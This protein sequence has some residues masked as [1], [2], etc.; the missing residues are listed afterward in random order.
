MR[1]DERQNRR[2]QQRVVT[3]ASR[4]VARHVEPRVPGILHVEDARACAEG[5]FL[6]GVPC[7]SEPWSEVFL[8]VVNQA[9]AEAAVTSLL[10]VRRQAQHIAIVDVAA[11]D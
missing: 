4:Q 3:T 2:Q 8:V 9:V 10:D 7:P 1:S 6:A 5:P 11:A